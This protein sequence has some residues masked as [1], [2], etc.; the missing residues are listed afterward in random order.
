MPM[1]TFKAYTP[2]RRFITVEDF[3][4]ITKTTPE[5]SLVSP[6]RKT[7]GRNNTGSITMRFRGGGHK[8]AYRLIDFKRDKVGVPAKVADLVGVAF[9]GSKTA[10]S[11][12]AGYVKDHPV[13]SGTV[14]AAVAAGVGY[15]AYQHFHTPAA[16]AN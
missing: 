5:K 14:A 8:R 11:N 13:I 7:G 6:L 15:L 9:Q 3:S 12:V 1:K 10:A 2:S 16:P 4:E